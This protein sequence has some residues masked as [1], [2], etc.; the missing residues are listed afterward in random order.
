[1]TFKD[2]RIETVARALCRSRGMD[3]DRQTVLEKNAR[4]SKMGPQWM[5]YSGKAKEHIAAWDTLKA[6]DVTP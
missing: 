3:P 2:P 4:D 5:T 1:M 6:M